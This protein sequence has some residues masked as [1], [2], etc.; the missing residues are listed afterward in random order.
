MILLKV[1]KVISVIKEYQ[2][3]I[4]IHNL[5]HLLDLAH[6]HKCIKVGLILELNLELIKMGH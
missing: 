5:Q 6:L 1:F 4:I 2:Y 3:K